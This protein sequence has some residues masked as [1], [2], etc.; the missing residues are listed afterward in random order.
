[1]P[2]N[3]VAAKGTA[4][5]SDKMLSDLLA[6]GRDAVENLAFCVKCD[7]DPENDGFFLYSI[8][9]PNRAEW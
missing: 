6:E 1:M 5:S 8:C 3:E 9:N 2:T 4:K 7:C